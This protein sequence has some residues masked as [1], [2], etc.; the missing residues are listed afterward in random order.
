LLAL[1]MG[2]SILYRK[3]LDY[4]IHVILDKV[5]AF[6]LDELFATYNSSSKF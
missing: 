2:K 1:W 6:Y 5:I 4:R 3:Y